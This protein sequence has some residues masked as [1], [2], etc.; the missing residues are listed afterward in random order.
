MATGWQKSFNDSA[1]GKFFKMNQR[2]TTFTT[3]L[4]AGLSTFVTMAYIIAVNASILTD[5]VNRYHKTLGTLSNL[6]LGV[7]PGL[8]INAYFA[9]TVVGFHGTGSVKYETALGAIFLEGII[10]AALAVF[11]LRQ[12][13][14]RMIPHSL[15]LAMGAGIGFFLAF[16]GAQSSEGI[17]LVTNDGATLVTLGGCDASLKA[18]DGTCLGGVMASAKLWAGIA[19]FILMGLLLM[20]RVRGAILIS[21][22]FISIISWIK[23][24]SN[25]IN[26]FTNDAAGTD[27]F[28]FFKKV[29]DAPSLAKTGGVLKFDYGSKDVWIAL[30]TFLYVDIF[31]TTGTLYSMASF[32]GLTNNRGEFEGGDVAFIADG[33]SI[34]LGSTV[35]T[36]PVTAFIE[37]AAG[38]AEGGKTGLTAFFVAVCFFI[39]LFFAPIFAS[40]PPWATGPALLIVGSMM[41]S[42][43]IAKIN[44]HY[45]GDSIPAFV[46]IAL[47]PLTYSVAYGLIG[48]IGMYI[49]ING[50]T[51]FLK[52]A[53]GGKIV[54]DDSAREIPPWEKF[55]GVPL[56]PAWLR[57][58]TGNYKESD[59]ISFT[60]SEEFE[61]KDSEVDMEAAMFGGVKKPEPEPASEET[62]ALGASSS[63]EPTKA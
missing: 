15:K 6:P 19:G 62:A 20:F 18:D 16:I 53:S 59:E 58:L 12:W 40:F 54:P 49:A 52:F 4:R 2:K 26:Y 39:S 11:G 28:V 51:A 33:V 57:K 30:I 61:K 7:A 37:S 22:L 42:S 63:E 43:N 45:Y 14:A 3:E 25:K 23:T 31:D 21:I 1:I 36:S 35:G 27:R 56:L 5:S 8:G 29:V 55:K 44:W 41:M 47:M 34:M 48:G 10:F 38:I 32:A 50:V 13:L 24:D 17:G 46:C 60:D 9:Y